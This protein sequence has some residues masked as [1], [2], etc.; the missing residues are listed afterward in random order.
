MRRVLGRLALV[1]GVT[2]ALLLLL[3]ALMALTGSY[4]PNPPLY[5]GDVEAVSDATT[6]PDVGWHLPPGVV[7]REETV[8]Y[9]MRY[10][11]NRQGFRDREPEA[12]PGRWR[13]AFLGDSYTFGSG[14]EL[15]ETFVRLIEKRHRGVRTDN[16]G[17]GG[18]GVDQMWAT[19]R[20]Y[21]LGVS[22][23]VVV[24]CFIHYDLDRSLTAYR[25]GH[26][27]LAKPTFKLADGS[28]RPLTRADR[29]TG[30]AGWLERR[31]HLVEL[32]RRATF[33][34]ERTLPVGYRWRLNRALFAAVRD[35]CR[36]AGIPLVVVHIPVNR[37][38]PAPSFAREMKRLGIAYLDLQP[39]L[40][41]DF[42]PLYFPHDRHF[43]PAGHRWAA[44]AI[45]AFLEERGLLGP[46]APVS[47]GPER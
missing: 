47:P 38:A 18:F 39:L 46:P 8:D 43:T 19:L 23:D 34:L 16:F 37:A 30:L 25:E 4:E 32:W 7:S 42:T 24:L 11:A 17:I 22:P 13:I 21:A 44:D 27:W 6:D 10:R 3:E 12:R 1:V 29:P 31:S 40:P 15:R 2:L 35:D 14:V 5:P 41:D 26:A 9:R 33:G 36:A 45:D 28:L 20:R